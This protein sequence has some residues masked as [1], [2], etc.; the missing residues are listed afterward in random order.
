MPRS[1][2][3]AEAVYALWD[4]LA[5]FPAAQTDAALV[6]LMKTL[7]AWTGAAN[8]VWVGGVRMAHGAAARKDPQ[9]GWRGRAV[10]HLVATPEA[11]ARSRAAARGQ[12]V[13]PGLTTRAIV[14]DAGSFRVRRLRDGFVD[15]RAF[16]RTEHYRVYYQEAGI[17]D[18]IWAAYPVN[19]DAESYFLF[20]YIDSR[21]SFSAADVALVGQVLRGVKWFHRQLLLSHNLLLANVPLA[22]MQR[23]LLFS[24][25]SDCTEKTIASAIGLTPGTT[26]QYAVDLYRQFGVKG[27]AGLMA[28]WLSA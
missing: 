1:T 23:R 12:D 18:R 15:L 21:R 19:R 11:L 22:P 3:K 25:L 26:H 9:Q 8:A 24:L 17:S 6:H 13:D 28:L 27:R 5:D 10:R 4:D 14:A 20:D 2:G 16:R 7:C